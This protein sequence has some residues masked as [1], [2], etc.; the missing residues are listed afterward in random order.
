M[1]TA[2]QQVFDQQPARRTFAE[3][4]AHLQAGHKSHAKSADHLKAVPEILPEVQVSIALP[5]HVLLK[6]Q[7]L[8]RRQHI[9]LNHVNRTMPVGCHVLA[10]SILPKDVFQ[11]ELGRF[12]MIG[13]DFHAHGPENTLLLPATASGAQFL[14]LPRHPL[15]T[16]EAHVSDAFERINALRKTVTTDHHHTLQAMQN[17]DVSRLYQSSERHAGYRQQLSDLAC[18]IAETAFG[19]NI[20]EAH[21]NRFRK[22]IQSL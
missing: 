22:L 10:W 6:A 17:G 1:A 3:M 4:I 21:E 12:L 9:L 7:D 20:W 8:E 14:S 5:N 11:S 15:V 2:A 16:A 13:Y 19:E 18:D